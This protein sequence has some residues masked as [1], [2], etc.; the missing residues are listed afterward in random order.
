MPR[1]AT[2]HGL[3]CLL[4][5]NEEIQKNVTPLI[6]T[7][8]HPVHIVCCFIKIPFGL[9]KGGLKTRTKMILFSEFYF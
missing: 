7:M 8:S 5:Q 3:N 6:Y 4:R 2:F 9:K 1:K